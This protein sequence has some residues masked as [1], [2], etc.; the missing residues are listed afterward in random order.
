MRQRSTKSPLCLFCIGHLLLAV[1][2]PYLQVW[3]IY[4]VRLRRRKR[5]CFLC[6]SMSIS[7]SFLVRNGSLCPLSPLSAGP[8]LAW[9][10]VDPM[11]DAGLCESVCVTSRVVSG[12]HCFLE[13]IHPLWLLK[14]SHLL[15]HVAPW[16][17]VV[18][19]S[20]EVVVDEDT[21]FRTETSKISHSLLIV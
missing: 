17:P 14:S 6:K 10:Y 18:I 3:L 16:A 19:R 13:I 20:R 15:C 12:R 8:C 5:N 2:G 9:S 11:H 21:L 1:R 4:P 7:D